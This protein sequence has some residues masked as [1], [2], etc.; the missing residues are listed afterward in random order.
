MNLGFKARIYLCVG[1]LISLA[2]ITLMIVNASIM[3][4]KMVQG[5][6]QSTANKLEYHVNE[7]Q[8]WMQSNYFAVDAASKQF[9][10]TL[11]SAENQLRIDLLQTTTQL[12]NVAVVYE[13]GEQYVSLAS[14]QTTLT[15]NLRT[16]PWYRA[17]KVD[18]RTQIS[19]IYNDIVSGSQVISI[20]AP[21]IENGQF[22][23]VL[24]GDV[25]L[26][27]VIE[28]VNNMRFAG[29]AAVLAD[30]NHVLFASDDPSDIGRTP[31]Q[32]SPVFAPIEASFK[33]NESG[34]ISFPYLG[35]D[36]DGYHKRIQLSADM[37][38]TLMVF[39]DKETAMTPVWSAIKY[40]AGVGLGLLCVSLAAVYSVIHN[41]YRPLIRLKEAVIDLSSGKGDLTRRLDANGHDDLAQI[42]QGFNRF[43]ADLQ[44]MMQ[45]VA[46]ASRHIHTDV[47]QLSDTAVD[48][49]KM[50]K[51]HQGE[52]EQ[53]VTAITE[54]AESAKSVSENVATSNQHTESANSEAQTSEEIVSNAVSTVSSLVADVEMMSDRIQV[55]NTDANQISDVLNVIEEIS[56][57]TNLLALNA[58]I[59]A[60]RAGEQ[61]RGF[62]VVADE[63]RALAARTQQSTT[64]IS[65]M[66]AKLLD[67]TE[68]VVN[69]MELTKQQCKTTAEKTSEV[70]VSLSAMR[71]AVADIDMLTSHIATATDEQT[72]VTT[73]VS[74]NMLAIR[75][76]VASL[77]ASGQ[78]T[79]SV[80]QSLA[81]ANQDL[82]KMVAKFKIA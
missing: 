11:S 21:L 14:G 42:S 35:I 53:V 32:I 31:A 69:A 1:L 67:G 33:Q 26:T 13:N 75:D 37:F 44:E 38:W 58:A 50:L 55:M 65:A 63:V 7:I 40:S 47:D 59:E 71:G 2:L 57:Q 46:E 18:N 5:L 73:E 66:L 68:S 76:I 34:L 8:A 19:E 22:T 52:T 16:R 28:Q 62:A 80:T 56:E 48:N 23:G 77:V 81:Q 15:T 39:I 72:S 43:I 49:E 6:T 3:R 36:F 12:S 20:A 74:Q 29:G 17:V 10:Q 41:A 27:D 9:S 45:H 60:A 24:V 4:E 78:Q 61:G 30:H 70:S 25:L 54:M 79:V 64:D 51:S 82:D